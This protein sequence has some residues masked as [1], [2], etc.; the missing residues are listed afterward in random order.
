MRAERFSYGAEGYGEVIYGEISENLWSA[1][2]YVQERLEARRN[3]YP[4][5]PSI[6]G[7]CSISGDRVVVNVNQKG[8]NSSIK[9]ELTKINPIMLI[10]EGR[11]G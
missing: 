7:E 6:G 10:R 4:V 11:K 5:Y 1:A 8:L 9:K 3:T 2:G